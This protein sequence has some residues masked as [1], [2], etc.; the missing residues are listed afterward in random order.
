MCEARAS[1][2]TYLQTCRSE[3]IYEM[4]NK[5]DVAVFVSSV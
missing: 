2:M 1:V 5:V 3:I 4:R